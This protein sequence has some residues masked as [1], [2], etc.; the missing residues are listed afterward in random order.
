MAIRRVGIHR[1]RGTD[2]L[3]SDGVRAGATIYLGG[4][5]A[6]H[7]PD[8]TRGPVGAEA[9]VIL[10]DI[11]RLLGELGGSLSDVVRL[12]TYLTSLEYRAEVYAAIGRRFGDVAPAS[13]G[14]VI[15]SLNFPEGRV[16]IE[17]TAVVEA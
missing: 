15:S 12:T 7:R 10:D 13:T 14:L 2:A 16:E 17:A 1:G 4:R 8:V 6:G 5:T 11:E 9:E 3:F